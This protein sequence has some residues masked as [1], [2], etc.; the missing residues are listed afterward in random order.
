MHLEILLVL[1]YN[2][3]I[4]PLLG[5]YIMLKL[6]RSFAFLTVLILAL[7]MLA[8]CTGKEERVIRI[9]VFEP[10][11]GENAAGGMQEVLGIRYAWAKNSKVT[12]GGQ[13]Y[14][15]ELVE[16]DNAS[17]PAKAPEAARELVEKNV[18]LVLGTYGSSCAIASGSVFAEN[19]IPVIGASCTNPQVT[20]GNDFYFRVCFIDEFQGTAMASLAAEQG[21]MKVGVL[22]QKD[23]DYSVG[24]SN[25]FTAAFKNAGGEAVEVSYTADETDFDGLV[26]DFEECDAI[27]APSSIETGAKII[28]AIRSVDA[29]CLI[30]GGDTWENSA[31]IREVGAASNGVYFSTAFDEA[32]ESNEAG[33]KFVENFKKWLN[34]D[35]SNLEANGGNDTVAAVSAL[36]YDAYM[37]A[38]KAL[39]AADSADGVAIRNALKG[40]KLNGVTGELE[41][42]KKG[43]AKKD[44]AYIKAINAAEGTFEFVM[45]QTVTE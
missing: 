29:E 22:T 41:F 13:S 28:K 45:T 11:S 18:S 21:C 17:D 44:I 27:F 34:E 20:S 7:S 3:S 26:E 33:K 1:V 10:F 35:A 32:D 15:I 23:D 19:E 4:I 8:G 40:V 43:D 30:L 2:I 39:E 14:K 6:R 5:G 24:L 36:G 25:F 37:A 38:I 12:L 16:V 31:L 9:G 42:D